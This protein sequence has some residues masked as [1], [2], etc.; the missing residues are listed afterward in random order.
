[1]LKKYQPFDLRK[2]NEGHSSNAKLVLHSEAC[3]I[4]AKISKFFCS[5]DDINLENFIATFTD[6][7][8]APEVYTA[9]LKNCCITPRAPKL[10]RYWGI[11]FEE[12]NIPYYVFN[13]LSSEA[14]KRFNDA[15]YFYLEDDDRISLDLEKVNKIHI[16]GLSVWFYTFRNVDHFLR[17][18]LPS[19][20]TLK[21]MGYDFSALNFICPEIL[22]D[23]IDFLCDFGIDRRNIISLDYQWLSFDELIIP[24]FS[25]F[26]HLHTLTKYYTEITN[27]PIINSKSREDI[28]RIYVSRANAK[29]RRVINED[30]IVSELIARGFSIIEPGN[31]SKLEQREIFSN[32]EVVIGPHGM[33]IANSVFS[34]NLKAI[35]EIMNTDYH[36]ISYFRTAQLKGC[37][38][39]AYYVNP[40]PLDASY[41]N[42]YG[43]IVIHKTKFLNFLDS[44]LKE[45]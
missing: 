31:Y 40:L 37:L 41:N 4:D 15:K 9:I 10:P 30:V 27:Y 6:N 11:F 3:N 34:K 45:I 29:M 24:C 26:G 5:Q 20:V 33:G 35:L 19:L 1:M 8:K 28:K 38:Y 32:A 44:I 43:D 13:F 21:Q 42:N 23:I 12:N 36:R 14:K 17:E 18:C 22:P 25:T 39:A 16:S 7:Y 2:I